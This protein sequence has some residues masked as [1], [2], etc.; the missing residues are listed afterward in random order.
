MA[1]TRTRKQPAPTLDMPVDVDVVLDTTPDQPTRTPAIFDLNVA[2]ATFMDRMAAAAQLDLATAPTN[3]AQPAPISSADELL[4]DADALDAA[5]VIAANTRADADTANT[6]ITSNHARAAIAHMA[7]RM[8]VKKQYGVSS[9]VTHM[10]AVVERYYELKNMPVPR[11]WRDLANYAHAIKCW[12]P[13]MMNSNALPFPWPSLAKRPF[14]RLPERV[15]NAYLAQRDGYDSGLV[16]DYFSRIDPRKL[17][18]A[19]LDRYDDLTTRVDRR[20][21]LR[22]LMGAE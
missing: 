17:D 19:V 9:V 18:N 10:A 16:C 15:L 11:A 22:E 6:A 1:K 3:T 14:F 4:N 13:G 8:M 2:R 5:R 21:F 7:A 12:L 20:S